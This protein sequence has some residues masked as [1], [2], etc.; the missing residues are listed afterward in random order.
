V[1]FWDS[2]A[3]VPLLAVQGRTTTLR[4]LVE[5]DPEL[6]VWWSTPVECASA[7][8]RLRREGVLATADESRLLQLVEE[9]RESWY[10]VQPTV[11]LRDV[12]G[13]LLRTHPLRAADAL[14][15]AAALVWA[16]RPRG[17]VFVTLDARLA[18]AARLEGFTV[19]PEDDAA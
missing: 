13:R 5:E 4:Q 16:G 17:E 18:E 15:L 9:L 19:A 2:S 7:F 6:V 11:S 12:A 10:E 14:Q 1:R 8:A 3:L